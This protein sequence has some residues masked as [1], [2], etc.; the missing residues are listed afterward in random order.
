MRCLRTESET[1]PRQVLHCHGTFFK[2]FCRI[3][4]DLN[5]LSTQMCALS[6]KF[7][8][9]YTDKKDVSTATLHLQRFTDV[10]KIREINNSCLATLFTYQGALFII[11]DVYFSEL[12]RAFFLP[13]DDEHLQVTCHQRVH[14]PR[15]QVDL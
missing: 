9:L 15:T 10:L 13:G 8:D 6:I 4:T 1:S 11:I 2:T 12:H 7:S 14:T 3:I 5:I